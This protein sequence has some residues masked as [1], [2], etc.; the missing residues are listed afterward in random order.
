MSFKKFIVIPL[1]V[2]L[3]AFTI[4]IVDQLLHGFV[5]PAG[6]AGF[7]WIAF[8]AWAMYFLAGC[9]LKGAAKTFLGYI[10]GIVASIAIMT[11]G[12]QLGSLGFYA[13]PVAVF[14]VVIPVM[15]LEKVP[16][17]DFVPALFVGAGVFF[18]F[19]SYVP[20]ATFESATITE[21]VYCIV[22]LIYGY[23]TVTLRG[24]YEARVMPKPEEKPEPVLEEVEA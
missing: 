1:M 8:Q 14:V 9:N 17:L 10:M 22:G 2:A 15:C 24:A 19:M 23:L 20:N 6:N 16:W 18:G 21:I 3:L 12:T 5:P 11:I 7:G 13:F 4:Q